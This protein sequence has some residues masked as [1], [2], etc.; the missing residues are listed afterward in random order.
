MKKI[1]FQVHSYLI[2]NIVIYERT[3]NAEEESKIL[4]QQDSG[5]DTI[6]GYTPKGKLHPKHIFINYRTIT[7]INT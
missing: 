7:K 1:M 2:Y 6:E 4:G 5:L 3:F